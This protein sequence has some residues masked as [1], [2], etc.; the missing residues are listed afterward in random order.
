MKK[1]RRR[2][3]EGESNHIYQR[4]VYGVILFYDKEDFLL[5]YMIVSVTVK[6]YNVRV[7]Q[8]CL[9]IDHVHML[10]E[11]E[12]LEVLADFVRDYT[13]IFAKEYNLSVGRSGRLFAKSF[14][15][16]PKKGEKKTRS[17]IVYIGNNP[18]EKRLCVH[19]EDYRWGFL[20][21]IHTRNP[22][23][24]HLSVKQYSRPLSRA[25]K[26]VDAVS[27]A[28]GYLSYIQLCQMFA[29]LRDFEKEILTDHIISTYYFFDT[30]G[31]LSYY[32][33]YEQMILAMRSTTGA[34]YD[35]KEV[36][37][38]GNDLIYREMCAYLQK[39][40]CISPIRSVLSYSTARKRQ[41]VPLL[42]T[43][44]G[45]TLYE[46]SKFLHLK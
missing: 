1:R 5:F 16:A 6:K 45:A 19:P 9:M 39:E 2:F 14:G 25:I 34:E 32:D 29:T 27:T 31:L 12:S 10:A 8:M 15:S 44:T 7:L 36:R 21:Y 37:I 38:T 20:R 17:T 13:S 40:L 46:I 35:I 33:S 28:G 3:I 42:R 4:T 41:L 22:F 11:S 18:V 30:D 26:I 23:S 24:V 43:H